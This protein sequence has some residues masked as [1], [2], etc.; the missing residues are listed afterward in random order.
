MMERTLLL[1]LTSSLVTH[2][3][4]PSGLAPAFLPYWP[5]VLTSHCW[6]H[7]ADTCHWCLAAH[8]NSLPPWP[9]SQEKQLLWNSKAS[10]FVPLTRFLLKFN[11]AHFQFRGYFIYNILVS[12]NMFYESPYVCPYVL[13]LEP[14]SLL[15]PSH[16]ARL[17]T[18][19]G[20]VPEPLCK[21]LLAIYFIVVCVS[22]F[23]FCLFTSPFFPP[24]FS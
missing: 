19:P 11:I 21:F 6:P 15:L 2:F 23:P 17:F 1:F 3:S 18:E 16:P 8:V 20:L 13:P 4:D 12:I 7:T 10:H 14:P 24:I 22:H 5:L 9:T